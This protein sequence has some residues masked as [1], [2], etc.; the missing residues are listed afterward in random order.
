MKLRLRHNSVRLRL[1]QGEVA[2]LRDAGSIEE[3]VEFGPDQRLTYRVD[4]SPGETSIRVEYNGGNILLS[5]PAAMV[6]GW[7]N[8][9][10]VGME[11]DGPLRVLIE[12]DFK[13]L[14]PSDPEDNVDTF[15][16][17]LEGKVC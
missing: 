1:T 3:Y 6:T 11:A 17:P 7:A 5:V 16:N 14:D 8:S 10:Q 2:Q 9:E 13:C 4:S 15:P 12:K